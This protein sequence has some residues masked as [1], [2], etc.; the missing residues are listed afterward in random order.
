[1]IRYDPV[2]RTGGENPFLLDSH[3]PR[4]PLDDYRN[5]ELRYRSLG[6]P[7]RPSTTG[8]SAS[9]NKPTL[10]AGSR[11]DGFPRSRTL[12]RRRAQGTLM[13]LSTRYMGLK[14]RNPLVAAASPLSRTVEDGPGA[15]PTPA[16]VRCYLACRRGTG[17]RSADPTSCRGRH[18][19]LRRSCRTSAHHP[20]PGPG[21]RRYLSLL[22]RAA[23]AVSVARDRQ[24]QQAVPR[25]GNSTVTPGQC[26]IP[27]RP[28]SN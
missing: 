27:A 9:P 15:S 10:S 12:P 8:F 5:R 7:I 14:L 13:E 11:G 2:L 18:R 28:Q 3:R 17:R 23:G 21:P 22:E 25:P 6:S 4:I 1:M 19:E 26:R 16:L 20:K 24:P